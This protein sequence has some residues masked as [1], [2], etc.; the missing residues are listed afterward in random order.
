M[1]EP[2]INCVVVEDD[3]VAQTVLEVL[4]KKTA[5]LDLK[6]SFDDPVVASAYLK[7]EKVDLI[8]LDMEM[9]GISG[10]QLI[11]LLDYKPCV[12]IVS[13]KQQYALEAFE[14]N[15]VDYLLKPVSEY[16]RFLK[17]VLKV[18]DILEA[19]EKTQTVRPSKSTPL[20]VKVDSLLHNIDLKSI[21]WIEAYGD[22]VKINTEEKMLMV[23]ST[24]KAIEG[25]LP[26]DQFVRVHRSYIVNVK[27]IDNIDPNNLQIGSKIL[28]ISASHREGLINKINLL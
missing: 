15:V 10:L 17:A 3:L 20:F 21:L 8:F 23:L 7:N 11:G 26:D 9:P 22:Y 12:I 16:S 13:D 5:F 14:H 4:I 24:L 19:R 1:R 6:K 25:K 27:R 28:P 2:G 18:K